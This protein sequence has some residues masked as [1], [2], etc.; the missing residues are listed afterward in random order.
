MNFGTERLGQ[1]TRTLTDVLWIIT[2]ITHKKNKTLKAFGGH[3][4]VVPDKCARFQSEN[5][6]KLLIFEKFLERCLTKRRMMLTV[7]K[8]TCLQ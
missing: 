5:T 6:G 7:K 8:F 1:T 4:T 2:D 3:W